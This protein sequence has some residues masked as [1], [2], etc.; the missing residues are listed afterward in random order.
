MQNWKAS[1]KGA[2]STSSFIAKK[3]RREFAQSTFNV[4]F[5]RFLSRRFLLLHS[6][7]DSFDV[8]RREF[9][10]EIH[11]GFCI[12]TTTDKIF[13]WQPMTGQL[14]LDFNPFCKI[15][16]YWFDIENCLN[17]IFT[18]VDRLLKRIMNH[19]WAFNWTN[20][21]SILGTPRRFEYKKIER[22]WRWNWN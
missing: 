12:L 4:Q 18:V 15:S 7:G 20:T 22:P 8:K 13:N 14:L 3:E 5:H 6:R 21:Y 16:R 2:K 10:T 11:C 9:T 1:R 17:L 19:S